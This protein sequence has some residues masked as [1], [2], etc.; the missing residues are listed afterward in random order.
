MQEVCSRVEMGTQKWCPRPALLPDEAQLRRHPG[1]SPPS[2]LYS[3]A[4][5]TPKGGEAGKSRLS[6]S[7]RGAGV[8]FGQK[9]MP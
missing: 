3:K 2:S 4:T 1:I 6:N 9:R 8:Q 7:F 5:H